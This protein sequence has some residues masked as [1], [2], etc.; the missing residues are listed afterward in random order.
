MARFA[1]DAISWPLWLRVVLTLPFVAAAYVLGKGLLSAVL[2]A[3]PGA[4][5]LPF[6]LGVFL[7]YTVPSVRALWRP[8][9][10]WRHG[11]MRADVAA[12]RIEEQARRRS[13]DPEIDVFGWVASS[14]TRFPPDGPRPSLPNDPTERA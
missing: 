6:A 4:A 14:D 12:S 9:A 5:L 8:S 13:G 1:S 11:R 10:S 2:N 3:R 7:I